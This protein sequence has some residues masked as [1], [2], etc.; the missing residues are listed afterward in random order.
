MI[1]GIFLFL[2]LA[3][4]SVSSLMAEFAFG[5][6][7]ARNITTHYI[8]NGFVQGRS[9]LQQDLSNQVIAQVQAGGTPNGPFVNPSPYV[10]CVSQDQTQGSPASSPGTASRCLVTDTV[11]YVVDGQTS[12]GNAQGNQIASQV[13]MNPNV[14]E[15]R[16]AVKM[17]VTLTNSSGGT[18]GQRTELVTVRTFKPQKTTDPNVLIAAA[19]A[20]TEDSASNVTTSAAETGGC[21]P[22]KTT[23]CTT[24]QSA[25]GAIDSTVLHVIKPCVEN[26]NG[27]L[28]TNPA[29]G[30]IYG[31]DQKSQFDKTV[32]QNWKNGT[33]SS[34]GWSR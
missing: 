31:Q 4:V 21:D 14:A 23:T 24:D 3:V 10:E 20:G 9:Y 15:N 26:G 1:Q 13:Q 8:S 32:D 33:N 17:T 19:I 11:S 29:N 16:L 34:S 28:C 27:G 6:M 7:T 18:I 5:K 22:A 30:Q 12:G 25:T 2:I